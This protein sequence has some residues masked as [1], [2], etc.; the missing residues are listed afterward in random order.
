M[1]GATTAATY[2]AEASYQQMGSGGYDNAGAPDYTTRSDFERGWDNTLDFVESDLVQNTMMVAGVVAPAAIAGGG[3]LLGGAT[4]GAAGTAAGAALLP[5]AGVMAVGVVAGIAG[6][7]IG[8]GLGHLVMGGIFGMDRMGDGEIPATVGDPIAHTSGWGL[9]GAVALGALIAV[10]GVA[11]LGTGAVAIAVVAGLALGATAGFAS[12]AGQYGTNKGEIIEGSPNVFFENRAVARRDDRIKCDNHGGVQIIAQGNE[13]VFANNQPI[14][15]VGHKTSCDG[16]INDGR[17]SIAIDLDTNPVQREIDSGWADRWFRTAMIVADLLPFPKGGKG[18]NPDTPTPN[19]RPDADLPTTNRPDGADNAARP[20][21]VTNP[22]RPPADGDGGP[23]PNRTPDSDGPAPDRTPANGDGGPNPDRTPDANNASP[24][25]TPNH[26]DGGPTPGRTPDGGDRPNTR[27]PNESSTSD[28]TPNGAQ[29]T[30]GD[31]VDVASGLIAETRIDISIPGTVPLVLARTYRP[32]CE[33]IQGRHWAGT[34]AQHL[35]ISGETITWQ[36]EEGVLI[37]FHA[38]RED[39]RS[40]NIRFPHLTLEGRRSGELY[41][42]DRRRQFFTV[43]N[44]RIRNR[45]LLT[46]IEDRNGNRI[47]FVYDGNGLK[48]VRHSDGF[49]LSVQSRDMVIRR[50]VLNA[51]ESDDCGFVWTYTDRNVLSEVIS[52]QTGTLRYG[53]DEHERLKSWADTNQTQAFYDYGAHGRVIRNRSKTG[54]LDTAFDYD[55]AARR[56]FVTDALGHV[57]VYDWNDQGV[58]WRETDPTGREWLTEWGRNFNVL[59]R[60]DPLGHVTRFDYDDWGDLVRVT[61]PAGNS[62]SWS[63]Y[64]SGRIRS[65]TDHSGATHVFRYDDNGNLASVEQPDGNFTRYRRAANG[66]VL[67]VDHPGN[68]QERYSYDML[69]RPSKL[70]TVAGFEQHMHYD[71]EG[72]LTR[73]SDEIGA[74]TRWDHSRGVDNPRGNMRSVTLADGSTTRA[75][76]DSEGL[77]V[78]ATNAEGATRRYHFGAFDLFKGMTDEQGHE[79][80]F[81]HDALTR[82]TAVINQKGERYEFSYDACGR[83]TAERDYS[84]LITTYEY[85]AAGRMIRSHAPDGTRRDHLR[86]ALGQLLETRYTRGAE[87]SR[88]RFAYDAAGRVTRAENAESVVEYTYD[89]MG[90]ITSE[91]QNDREIRSEYAVDGTGR[92]AR[93]GDAMALAASYNTAGRLEELRI[94]GHGPLRFAYDPR[95]LETMRSSEAGFALT[96]GYNNVGLLVEQIAGPLSALPE[97]VRYGTLTGDHRNE[98]ITRAGA[99]AHRT[100]MWDRAHRAVSVN[101]RVTGEKRFEYDPR[102]QVTGVTKTDRRG[103]NPALSRFGYDPN[104]DLTEIATGMAREKLVQEAGRVHQRGKIHYRY[105]NAGRVIEKR[106]EE[107]G[108]RPRVWRMGWNAPGQLARLETPEGAVWRYG[109]DALGRRVRKLL[110]IPGGQAASDPSGSPID[111]SDVSYLWEC[112]QLVA[113][114]PESTPPEHQRKNTVHWVYE[115]G[116]VRPLARASGDDLHHAVNDHI[117]TLRELIAADGTTVDYRQDLTLWGDGDRTDDAKTDSGASP[118]SCPIRFQGQWHDSESGLHYNGFRYYDP[119][120][121]QYISPD[122]IGLAGGA[123]PQGYV[124]D[125][126][127]FIDPAGLNGCGGRTEPQH[128]TPYQ[129]LDKNAR[130]EILD[131]IDN[132]TATRDEYNRYQWDRRFNNRR[133]RGVDRFWRQERQRLRAGE[134]GTRNWSPEQRAEIMA[135]RRP[136]FD[137]STIEGHHRYNALDHPHIADDPNNIY[138]A[139]RNEHQHR[140][141]GGSWQNDTYGTPNNPFY[142]EEF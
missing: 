106:I 78:A 75:E 27:P 57:T 79:L 141:H 39:V 28:K 134:P 14:A 9:L 90:R 110:V 62:E 51:P 104:H 118:P 37:D 30:K 127:S 21:P 103:E 12:A 44:H 32:G 36:N 50:A 23:D 63:Y 91:R 139:T 93:T 49:S 120:S 113:E 25:R 42:Y 122:P 24:D 3:A 16:T 136:K 68:R 54:H 119:S 96:Q 87:V 137:G 35:K 73:F 20:D 81:E 45:L 6:N 67:R 116:T 18:P 115:P 69:G 76:Y 86:D 101:D 111:Q 5:A 43:F 98:H 41:V 70:R 83:I 46:R 125:P 59:S 10:V 29:S 100:Y 71:G 128:S 112:D 31:P 85:D 117:G 77:M 95:G 33:G 34:W 22:D 126:N 40:R 55:L 38:P 88:V 26:G 121:S 8:S 13:T 4:L 64:L 60:T 109:Y 135:G 48:E 138:P 72:R 84:G 66:Q 7:A 94:G 1:S 53:Y 133:A 142:P 56:T 82:L 130:Q 132:R 131:R 105:D 129:P 124:H 123:R 89:I 99:L 47:R 92:I 19:I 140:W 114:I 15:R 65:Y 17:K 102:G 108:F 80:R 74:E 2:G 61:D 97:E 11:T 58:V 52:S 107:P